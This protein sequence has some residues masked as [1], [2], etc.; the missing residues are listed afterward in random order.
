MQQN[1]VG[2]RIPTYISSPE[3]KVCKHIL[4]HSFMTASEH[5]IHS[6]KKAQNN[7]K[8]KSAWKC[9]LSVFHTAMP[10]CEAQNHRSE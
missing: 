2:S 8:T 9:I 1:F 4:D 3:M 7:S 5:M 6:R 10:A